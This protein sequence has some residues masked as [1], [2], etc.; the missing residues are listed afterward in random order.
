MINN[1]NLE[2]IDSAI[3]NIKCSARELDYN[4]RD[5]GFT[6]IYRRGD[7][8]QCE[9]VGVGKELN[10]R[11][12]AIV[13]CAKVDNENINVIPLTSKLKDESNCQFS[14]GK[15]Q[16]FYTKDRNNNLINTES[17]VYL[18]KLME[19]SRKRVYPKY[20]QDS[21][22]KFVKINGDKNKQLSVG[23]DIVNRIEESFRLFYLSDG[24]CLYE[25]I[26]DKININYQIDPSI[27]NE[28]LL[29]VGFRLVQS[30]S[31]YDIGEYKYLI[32]HINNTRYSI[33]F[34][35]ITTLQEN[36]HRNKKYKH[37]Y[38]S[39]KWN[40]NIRSVR[41]IILK[42]LFSRNSSKVSEAKNILNHFW[43]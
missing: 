24:Q 31:I 34:N 3:R 28:D 12:F 10:F 32:C 36:N 8:V 6:P 14:I 43:I 18:D 2:L 5:K 11:H 9:F 42:A 16:G 4:H 26:E 29:K 19:V 37:L 27:I 1:E 30:Y 33:K 21:S 17:F 38:N 25:L 40:N 15:V 35:K 7:I 41:K 13:W 22:G 39:I 20:E 23:D